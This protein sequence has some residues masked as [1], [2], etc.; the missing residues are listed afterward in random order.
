MAGQDGVIYVNIL[1]RSQ[2][3][4]SYDEDMLWDMLDAIQR[5]IDNHVNDLALFAPELKEPVYAEAIE[6]KISEGYFDFSVVSE[7]VV[8][9]PKGS[10]EIYITIGYYEW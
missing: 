6:E 4:D 2:E 5:T 1:D 8:N 7:I 9:A 3:E 10:G